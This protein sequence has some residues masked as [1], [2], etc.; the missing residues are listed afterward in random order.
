MKG[1]NHAL[2]NMRT[3]ASVNTSAE[4]WGEAIRIIE[5]MKEKASERFPAAR[6]R[7]YCH[8]V[9]ER[10]ECTEKLLFSL[11]ALDARSCQLRRREN[12]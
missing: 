9:A 4:R 10:R 11:S 7:N 5:M 3:L 8:C 1:I 2:E 6:V 12:T